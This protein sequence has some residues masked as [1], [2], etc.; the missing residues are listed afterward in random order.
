MDIFEIEDPNEVVLSE[1]SGIPQPINTTC[2]NPLDMAVA[3]LEM[4]QYRDSIIP[5]PPF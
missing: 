2:S 3:E 1:K 4:R 5:P